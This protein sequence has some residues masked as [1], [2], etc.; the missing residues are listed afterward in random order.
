M[1]CRRPVRHARSIGHPFDRGF[2]LT[3]GSHVYEYRGESEKQRM[4]AENAVSLGREH[5]MPFVSE[6]LAQLVKGIAM[7]RAGQ[8]DQA[9]EVMIPALTLW[10]GSGARIWSPYTKSIM[11]EA[12]AQLGDLKTALDIVDA[13]LEQI[14]RS[15]WEERSHLAEV[16]RVKGWMQSLLGDAKGSENSYIA[17]LSF[18]QNFVP[19]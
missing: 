7:V 16:L 13:M 9:L 19:L 10:D 11:A 8:F 3:T 1:P 12:Y 4:L 18:P 6:I 14:A 2:A 5:S 15:G 17:S